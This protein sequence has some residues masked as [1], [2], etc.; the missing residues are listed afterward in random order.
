MARHENEGKEETN[1][2]SPAVAPPEHRIAEEE[3][4]DPPE[5]VDAGWGVQF[6]GR[7]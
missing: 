2:D 7:R 3:M 6:H 5:S 4:E 1:E